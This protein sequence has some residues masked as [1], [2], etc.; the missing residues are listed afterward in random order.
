[1]GEREILRQGTPVQV[2]CMH[3]RVVESLVWEDCGD[4]VMVCSRGQFDRLAAGRAAPMPIGFK[5]ADV[6]AC[7]GTRMAS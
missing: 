1:M 4:V 3:G 6:Q 7:G 2:R 5:R